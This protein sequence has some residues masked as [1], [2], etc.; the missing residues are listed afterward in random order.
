[1][2]KTRRRAP[3][4][5]LVEFEAIFEAVKNWGRWG[6]DDE[7][8]TMN[9]ITPDHVKRAAELVK[10]GHSVSMATPINTV[11]GP[12]TPLPAIHYMTQN[13]DWDIGSGKLRFAM[14][15]LGME[16]HGDCHTHI[17][18][19]KHIAYAGVLSGG[20]PASTVPSRGAHGLDIT[21]YASGVVGR[22]VLLDIPRLRGEKWLDAGDGFTP[23][24]VRDTDTGQR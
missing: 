6:A 2:A 15:F 9:Y 7:R 8:G 23:G 3:N 10:S 11:A 18:A 5:S 20:R 24:Q 12:D 17:H 13:H 22:G 14:D 1:M 21:T 4:I 16:C 19:L